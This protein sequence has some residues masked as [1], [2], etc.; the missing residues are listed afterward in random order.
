[1][2]GA[3]LHL[4]RSEKVFA[5]QRDTGGTFDPGIGR[6]IEAWK[7]HGGGQVPSPGN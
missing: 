4:P 3:S 7:I 2:A 5:W 6:L 1:M